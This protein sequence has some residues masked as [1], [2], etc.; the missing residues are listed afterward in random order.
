MK[1]E[2]VKF[3]FDSA[4]G[5]EYKLTKMCRNSSLFCSCVLTVLVNTPWTVYTGNEATCQLLC[6]RH[7]PRP[8]STY[9]P[10]G[11]PPPESETRVLEMLPWNQ[12]CLSDKMWTRRTPG[13]IRSL[14][15]VMFSNF[16]SKF[17]VIRLL[18]IVLVVIVVTIQ[19]S[20]LL[21]DRHCFVCDK[22]AIVH[23]EHAQW[24]SGATKMRKYGPSVR[25]GD[26]RWAA[27]WLLLLLLLISCSMHSTCG[28]YI[29]F[30]RGVRTEL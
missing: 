19:I 29:L 25:E 26:P 24:I 22:C 15:L 18:N 7:L 28:V 21:I 9:T 8:T 20:C 4:A 12:N 1:R 17:S 10:Q 30:W 16:H 6:G 13:T 3:S 11:T 5:N 14:H 27:L 23:F 2:V